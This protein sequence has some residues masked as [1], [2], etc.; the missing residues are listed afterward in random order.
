MQD[1]FKDCL[2]AARRVGKYDLRAYTDVWAR[3]VPSCVLANFCVYAY[4]WVR[5]GW[6]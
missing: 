5:A 2:K 1:A 6:G 4:G 3:F